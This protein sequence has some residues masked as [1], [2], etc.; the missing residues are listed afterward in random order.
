[1][2]GSRVQKLLVAERPV[3][4][5]FR[6]CSAEWEQEGERRAKRYRAATAVTSFGHGALR[7]WMGAGL[8]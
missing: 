4:D 1:M 7:G 3:Q 6:S 2:T 5:L 8:G